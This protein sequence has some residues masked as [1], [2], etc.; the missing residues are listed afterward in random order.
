[1]CKKVNMKSHVVSLVKLIGNLPVISVNITDLDLSCL[2][3][4]AFSNI[5]GKRGPFIKWLYYFLLN[6]VVK[7]SFVKTLK[8]I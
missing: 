7:S 6:Q 5:Y 1:M 3:R 4:F 2:L 8:V